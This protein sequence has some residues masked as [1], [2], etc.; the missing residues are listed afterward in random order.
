MLDFD[1]TD[2]LGTGKTFQVDPDLYTA[3]GNDVRANWCY[4]STVYLTTQPAPSTSTA[5]PACP[6]CSAPD[7]IVG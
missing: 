4:G 2:P 5:R 1:A 7:S 3:A 6:M